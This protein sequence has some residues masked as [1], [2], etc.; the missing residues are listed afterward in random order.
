MEKSDILRSFLEKGYQIDLET[1]NFFSKNERLLQK[2][3]EDIEKKTAPSTITKD[4]VDLILEKDIDIILHQREKRTMTAEDLAKILFNKYTIIKKIIATHLDLINLLSIN[5]VS[6]KT[7][8]FSLI[9]IVT[10]IDEV[11][12][13]ITVADDTGEI[14]LSIDQ[15]I[16]ADI[17]LNDVLGFICENNG[18]MHVTSIVFPDIPLRRVVKNITD[19]KKIIFTEKITEAVLQYCEKEKNPC[20]IFTFSQ[21][22]EEDKYPQNVKTIH[23]DNNS[24][25]TA[26]IA[27]NFFI[28]LFNGDFLNKYIHDREIDEFMVSLL[29]KRYLNASNA[30]DCNFINEAFILENIP[31]VIVAK[32]LKDAIQT[33]YKGTTVLTLSENVFWVINLKTREIIK[34]S[35]T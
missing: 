33:N 6:E 15:K 2:F 14:I 32:G 4:F 20:Y 9:G 22:G 26:I 10:L 3:M 31:D 17:L 1:L 8:K 19:D 7:K 16:L 5:K 27:K 28:F 12:R 13:N 23:A 30:F 18:R 25:T 34:L 11:T 35:H 29:K 24:P 21:H